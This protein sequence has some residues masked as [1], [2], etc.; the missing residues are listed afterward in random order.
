LPAWDAAQYDGV[1]ATADVADV[2][3]LPT[4]HAVYLHPSDAP[5]RFGRFAAKI[6]RDARQASWALEASFGR[7]FRWDERFGTGAH[8]GARY[9]DI[10]VVKSK[11][12]TKRLGSSQQFSLIRQ[13]VDARF[14]NA[15][16]KYIVWLDAPSSLCGESQAPYDTRRSAA[17][18][19]EARTVS[20][21]YRYYDPNN[22][23]GGFCSPVLHELAHALGAI[24][25][26]APHTDGS[27]HCNDNGNDILCLGRAGTTVPYD[28]ALGGYYVDAGNDDYWNPAA[29]PFASSSAKLGWWTI[30]LSRFLCPPAA[31]T[32]NPQTGAPYT[33][34]S[35]AASPGY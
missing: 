29:D 31:G 35:V 27:G 5:S 14:K 4:I 17:N 18:S 10:T 8:A 34:C 30:N 13:E 3:S 15:N 19:A 9:L 11:Y 12:A 7:A 20:A 21:I 33:D 16:K 2:T 1:A 24:N 22:A 6:Q 26:A 23:E 28:P 32:V 25:P